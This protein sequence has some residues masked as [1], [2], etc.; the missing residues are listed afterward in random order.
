[1]LASQFFLVVAKRVGNQVL[2]SSE[3]KGLPMLVPTLRRMRFIL[4]SLLLVAMTGLAAT[5]TATVGLTA[6]VGTVPLSGVVGATYS[7]SFQCSNSGTEPVT[8]VTCVATGLP[9]WA[10]VA[11]CSPSVSVASLPVAPPGLAGIF[12]TIRCPV[13]GAPTGTGPF[14]LT[15]T[16]IGDGVTHVTTR[17]VRIY[18][19]ATAMDATLNLPP[20]LGAV[21]TRYE[22]RA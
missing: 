20:A 15:V 7:G 3:H 4:A 10:S 14:T 22:S 5:A 13:T 16:A 11:T 17:S 12:D 21:V 19:T 6:S 2:S 8:N 9:S 1:M 18:S